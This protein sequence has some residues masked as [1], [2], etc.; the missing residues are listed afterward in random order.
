MRGRGRGNAS[1]D[2]QLARPLQSVLDQNSGQKD[3]ITWTSRLSPRRQ[4]F[5]GTSETRNFTNRSSHERGSSLDRR[6]GVEREFDPNN[7][8]G[9]SNRFN[10]KSQSEMNPNGWDQDRDRN[11][12][13]NRGFTGRRDK[14]RHTRSFTK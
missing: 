4:G 14:S 6:N 7:G 2:S 8:R 12:V 5:R 3:S 9:R 1:N 10:M 13:Q 11:F